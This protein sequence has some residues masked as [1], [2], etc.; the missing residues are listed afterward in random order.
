MPPPVILRVLDLPSGW[1]ALDPVAAGVRTL[2]RKVL[3]PSR[4][5]DV[6]H[7]TPV[8]HP[9][10]PPLAQAALAGWTGAAVL[11][12]VELLRRDGSRS[13]TTDVPDPRTVLA[14][15]GLAGAT[16]TVV[17]GLAD[18]ADLH[19]DQQRTG[20][21][22]AMTMATT[23][24]LS[25]AARLTRRPRTSALLDVA[26]GVVAT[27][28]AALGGHLAFRWAAGPNHAEAFPHLAKEGWSRVCRTTDLED[29]KPIAVVVGDEPVV[30]VRR[31]AA[32]FALADRCSHLAGPLHEGE[33]TEV[34]GAACLVCPWHHTTFGLSDGS[35]VRGPGVAPQPVLDVRIIAGWVDVRPRPL[36]GVAGR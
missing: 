2:V 25:V 36:P 14:L 22:H 20:L 23:A 5:V 27:L 13:T 28:G 10:H 12:A 16:P 3:P 11:A 30:V 26:V 7:G 21:V 17:T 19:E 29:G 24:G 33:L 31:G 32:T 18:W 35:V 6:L 1:P 15:V 34:N 4:P 9:L 8:G